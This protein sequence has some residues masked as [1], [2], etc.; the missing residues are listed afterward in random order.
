VL[1][2]GE[3][4]TINHKC[5][6]RLYGEE[7]LVLRRRRRQRAASVT[8]APVNSAVRA[9]QRFSMDFVSDSLATGWSFRALNIVDD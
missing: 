5:L 6:H 8:R 2:E 1:L 9:G 4:M 7:G 3:G